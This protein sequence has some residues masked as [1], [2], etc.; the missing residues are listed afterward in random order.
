MP[1]QYLLAG[2]GGRLE[3]RGSAVQV[4][5][6][7]GTVWLLVPSTKQEAAFEFTQETKDGIPLRFKGLVVY[8]IT[9]P[10]AAARA[11]EFER[12]RETTQINNLLTHICLGELRHAVA[13]MTMTECIEQRKT[14]LSSVIRGALDATIHPPDGGDSWGLS[15]EVAQVAQVFIVDPELRQQLEAEVRN[16][17]RL[18]SGQS[19]VRTAE[20]I[21]IAEMTSRGRVA[22]Q[23][24]TSDR[25]ALLRSESLF[26]AEM[27]AQQAR[28]QVEAPV[29]LL[30]IEQERVALE[31]ELAMRSVANRVEAVKVEH[32]L[33]RARAEQEMR[34]E[35][36]PLEQAPRI[37]EAAAG[38]L[39]GTNLTLF[40]DE[41]GL[42]RQIGPVLGMV[43]RAVEGTLAGASSDGRSDN[44]QD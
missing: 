16:E 39:H 15:V 28:I 43:S 2:R 17:I 23:K 24:L 41:A 33:Q 9:D 42:L 18:R 10:V 8:R 21:Q 26:E 31:Q 27:A 34:R 12:G 6:M 37:V 29:K 36:M 38:M 13:H 30:Q 5:L 4:F 20:E 19:D 32:D 14:T 44:A 3:D 1:N 22:D 35:M 7:P 25:D 40:A 11:F